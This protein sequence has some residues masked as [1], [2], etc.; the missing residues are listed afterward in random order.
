MTNTGTVSD[1]TKGQTD[2]LYCSIQG[3][4]SGERATTGTGKGLD[5]AL[6]CQWLQ[7]ETTLH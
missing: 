2:T 5:Q 3:V 4:R 1:T 6:V 7:K